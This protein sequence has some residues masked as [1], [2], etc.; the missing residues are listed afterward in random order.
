M[1]IESKLETFG[2]EDTIQF[3]RPPSPEATSDAETLERI[4][5]YQLLRLL[6]EGGMGEVWLADQVEPVRRR[7]AVKI[8][9]AGMD[10]RQ[11]VA[12]F[13]SERQALAMMDHPAIAKVFDGGTTPQGRP[14]F[15]MEFVPGLSINQHC[16]VN[17]LSTTKRLEL[18]IRACDG[19]QHAHQKAVIHR[20]LKPSNILVSLVDDK[21]QVKIIDFGI[22]KAM[23]YRLTDKTVLTEFGAL[24]GTPEYMSPEQADVTGQDVDTRTDVYSL[25]VLLYELLTGE[26]PFSSR[27]LRSLGYE[28][29]VRTLREI[30][31]PRPST[32]LT[33]LGDAAESA[34]WNRQSEP[35]SLRR[36]LEGDLDAI[37]M[38]ALEKERARRYATPSEMAA[39]I[40]RHLRNEPVIARPASQ[41]YRAQKYIMRHRVG[42]AV[43]T[44][45]VVLL[46]FFAVSMAV[47]AK[48]IALERDR[49]ARQAAVAKRVSDFMTG[50][51]RVSSPDQA[52]GSPLTAREILDK[53][54]NEI[55]TE[56]SAEPEVQAKL[57]STMGIVY[58]NLGVFPR[59]EE[60]LTEALATQRRLLGPE[61]PD[62]LTTMTQLA[63]TALLQGH[64]ADAEHSL[65]DAL[66]GRQKVLGP[67][68]P[69]TLRT[70]FMLATV[71]Q[72]Q[73]NLPEAEKL[74]RETLDI[75]KR[76]LG[77]DHPQTLSTMDNLATVIDD[78]GRFSEAEALLRETLARQQRVLGIDH[79][80]TS[81]TRG[82]LST[83]LK[84]E[85]NLAEA[86]KL[87]REV[88]ETDR[89]VNGPE[90]FNTLVSVE[91]LASILAAEGR[92]GEAESLYRE[93][94]TIRR[95]VLGPTHPD[96]LEG[97]TALGNVLARE[98][99]LPEAEQLHREVLPIAARVFGA[100]HPTVAFV[101]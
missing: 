20:D 98:G 79:P 100:Q 43:A 87:Q 70:R 31:P 42:V 30:D 86:E 44:A 78:E 69:D 13:E 49:T 12:R 45:F 64:F 82:D 15:V 14:Y 75:Q 59:G 10:T 56:L 41:S 7:V 50:M 95:R 3:E 94:L 8:I 55:R 28:D 58:K 32:K 27:Q 84:H 34:A 88:L 93:L 19:V 90:H 23:G 2:A 66:A 53:A 97:T 1:S 76:V 96:T 89:R 72:R 6:G 92:L 61:H 37:T 5:P 81:S 99:K 11:V 52:K 22:A 54:S 40:G 9:K 25:G 60:L 36:S 65:R 18:F 73:G 77:P 101:K 17:R 71:V 48:R 39:D 33:T 74:M 91:N 80:D 35:G 85:G 57:M 62:T 38:K 63:E 83:V 24:I 26:L 68:H 51:F 21:P 46:V 16:D 47:Q 4:G 29:L 67:Q